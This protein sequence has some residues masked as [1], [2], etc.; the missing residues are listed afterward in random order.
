MVCAACFV[1]QVIKTWKEREGTQKKG[2][3]EMRNK[4]WNI[5]L[6][7]LLRRDIPLAEGQVLS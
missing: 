1:G 3:E 4:G 7:N 5:I 6:K 2:I